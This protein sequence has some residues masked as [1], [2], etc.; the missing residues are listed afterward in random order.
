MNSAVQR[1]NQYEVKK[2]N[3]ELKTFSLET[4][5]ASYLIQPFCYVLL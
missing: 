2:G 1:I 5:G 3:K 4:I